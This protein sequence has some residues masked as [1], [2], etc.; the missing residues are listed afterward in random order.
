MLF[1][2]G[3]AEG[4]EIGIVR[5]FD[6]HAATCADESMKFFHRTN[7]IAQVFNHVNRAELVEGAIGKR[8]GKPIQIA[9][10]IGG[11][12][13]IDIDSDCAGILFH[14]AADIENPLSWLLPILGGCFRMRHEFADLTK[15]R[16]TNA[17]VTR[18]TGPSWF[19]PRTH[20]T[21]D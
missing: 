14:A 21:G 11:S 19:R 2:R 15:V 9:D 1:V 18:R 4:A 3:V 16:L 5:R 10:H 6:A 17:S 12:R 20:Q 13:A 7:D 8:I